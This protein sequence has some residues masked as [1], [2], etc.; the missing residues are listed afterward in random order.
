MNEQIGFLLEKIIALI[1]LGALGVSFYKLRKDFRIWWAGGYAACFVGLFLLFRFILLVSYPEEFQ[2]FSSAEMKDIF[3][4][5]I[6]FDLL[7]TVLFGGIFIEAALLPIAR[8]RYYQILAALAAAAWGAVA[9]TCVGDTIYFSFVK[10]HTGTEL[11]I[12]LHDTDF[13]LQTLFSN[14][15]GYTVLLTFISLLIIAASIWVMSKIY[16]RP[17]QKWGWY[18]LFMVLTSGCM[19]MT[20]RYHIR[21]FEWGPANMFTT[22]QGAS[23][24]K[25]NLTING[26]YYIFSQL[27]HQYTEYLPTAVSAE[28][29]LERSASLLSSP[30]EKFNDSNYP[31]M[32]T[33]Q[34]FNMNG[35]NYNLIILLLESWQYEYTDAL[36][37]THYGATPKLDK[38]IKQSVVFDNFYASGQRSING[39]GTVAMSIAQIAGLPNFGLGLEQ[40]NTSSLPD[41]LK[42]SGYSLLFVRGAIRNSQRIGD[43][44]LKIGFPMIYGKEDIP[45][46]RQ[47]KSHEFI[48]DYD[49]LL[50]FADKLKNLPQPFFAMFFSISTHS[51]FDL[52]V[53]VDYKPFPTD[54]P[55]EGYLNALSYMDDSVGK[56]MEEFKKQKLEE[57]TVLLILSDH[58]LGGRGRKGDMENKFH[59]PF[60]IYAP[61]LLKPKHT[62]L[63]GS[64]VDILPTVLDILNISLPYAA[65]GNSLFDPFAH[66]FAF[67]SQDGKVLV[68]KTPK[69]ML[70]YSVTHRTDEQGQV[71]EEDDKDL[72]ALNRAV[73][74]LLLTNRWAPALQ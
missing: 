65:M 50:F 48:G 16:S 14:Y 6:R 56:F 12:T 74:E 73:Y 42:K 53:P 28:E 61:K 1:W 68:W 15:L 54:G 39:N 66:H 22:L 35:K 59:I 33:R 37:G 41:L 27:Q 40:Y 8:K 60:L 63:V 45:A 5:G 52:G 34:Q 20:S 24:A 46:V 10:R 67:A 43:L 31:L 30:Q 3:I 64:Q 25:T 18:A 26:A 23:P 19:F 13:I 9:W 38:I 11:L 57:N 32:R 2:H 70:E 36:A 51:P 58:A 62:Q 29:A 4:R 44:M 17:K 7:S 21:P 47:Y 55:D 71:S 72:I 69:G 49:A